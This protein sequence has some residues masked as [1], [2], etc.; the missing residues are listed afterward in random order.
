VDD[1][2]RYRGI[3][4]LNDVRKVMFDVGRYDQVRVSDIMI[5]APTVVNIDDKMMDVLDKFERTGAWNLPV[6]DRYQRYRGLVSKSTIF[7][8]YRNQLLLR[9][10]T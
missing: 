9:T 5:E 8:V 2:R 10:N 6:I 1:Q 7:S 4:L 3:I